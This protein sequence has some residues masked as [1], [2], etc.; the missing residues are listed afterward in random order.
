MA[1]RLSKD[2]LTVKQRGLVK[3]VVEGKTLAQAAKDAGYSGSSETLRVE[4]HR[5][6]QK[7]HV[8]EAIEKALDVAGLT[9]EAQAQVVAEAAK[10]NKT[11]LSKFGQRVDLGPD[12]HTR[13]EA[14]KVAGRWRGHDAAPEGENGSVI[15]IGFFVLK[16][17]QARGLNM[18]EH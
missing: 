9:V 8:R 2:G 1:P 6:L 15:G 10:A 18:G 14:A 5:T 4:A 16:G 13:L 11:A 17:A 12:H 7:P 3:G